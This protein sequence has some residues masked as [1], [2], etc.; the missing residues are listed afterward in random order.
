MKTRHRTPSWNTSSFGS[1]PGTSSLDVSALGHH[2][3]N[4]HGLRDPWFALH[5]LADTMQGFVATRFLTTLAV[6][7]LISGAGSAFL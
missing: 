7:V 1:A 6:V 5:C 2:L 3:D 4:C